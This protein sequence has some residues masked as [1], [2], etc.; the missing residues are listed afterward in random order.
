MARQFPHADVLG[1]DLV[2]PVLLNVSEIPENCRFEVDDAN[3][4]MS[5]HQDTFDVVHVRATE[6]GINDFN[7]FLYEVARTLRP[8]GLVILITGLPVSPTYMIL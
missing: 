6:V 1:I 4:S 8:G 2:P 5:H 3:L 7:G